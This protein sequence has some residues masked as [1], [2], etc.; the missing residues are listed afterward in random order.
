MIDLIHLG[1]LVGWSRFNQFIRSTGFYWTILSLER[2]LRP[3]SAA[4][5]IWNDQLEV[6][7]LKRLL[8]KGTETRAR[9]KMVDRFV[10]GRIK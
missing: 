7:Y 1:R 3:K 2:I 8:K 6:W 5:R 9:A 4:I 10:S